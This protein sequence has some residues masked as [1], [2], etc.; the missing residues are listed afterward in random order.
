[1]KVTSFDVGRR[2]LAVAVV[3]TENS[4][5]LWWHIYDLGHPRGV[6][7]HRAICKVFD[8]TP[9]LRQ[10]HV[11]VER[12]PSQNPQMRVIEAII[13][14]YFIFRCPDVQHVTD[15]NSRFKLEGYPDLKGRDNYRSRKAASVAI[16][17]EFLRDHPQNDDVVQTWDRSKKKDDLADCVLQAMA[18]AKNPVRCQTDTVPIVMYIQA[19]EPKDKNKR[20]KI[21]TKSGVKWF[22]QQ[23]NS[24]GLCLDSQLKAHGRVLRSVL[25]H[26]SALEACISHLAI[27]RPPKPPKV[28]ADGGQLPYGDQACEPCDQGG[29]VPGL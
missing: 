27:P 16:M 28:K 8:D 10:P 22:I 21:Y 14:A 4:E 15:F 6:G 24:E 23:W 17:R 9:I 1:M 2:N 11:I 13:E 19:R 18:Y 29:R 7:V 3:D 5:V 26:W 20:G 25:K 12:Q